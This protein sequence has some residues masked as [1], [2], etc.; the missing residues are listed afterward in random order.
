MVWVGEVWNYFEIVS[1]LRKVFVTL[2][3]ASPRAI[4]ISLSGSVWIKWELVRFYSIS[5]VV[6]PFM[7][8]Q[9]A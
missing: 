3:H 1:L 4:S 9:H 7:V 5:V 2:C 8:E 6:T